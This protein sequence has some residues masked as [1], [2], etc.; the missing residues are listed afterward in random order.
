[1]WSLHLRIGVPEFIVFGSLLFLA[2]LTALFIMEW[3]VGLIPAASYGIAS[4]AAYAG[5]RQYAKERR[6]VEEAERAVRFRIVDTRGLCPVGRHAGEVITVGGAAVTPFV[7]EEARAV[8]QM[9]AQD[10][11]D[12]KDWCCPV[13][14]HLLVFRKEKAAA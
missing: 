1:M 14:E 3:P 8:L 4:V 11:Y 2:G 5:Y 12:G 13:Y 9:A 6:R 10:R 7:C